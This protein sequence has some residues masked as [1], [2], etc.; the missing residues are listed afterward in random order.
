MT[1]RIVITFVPNNASRRMGRD[2][3]IFAERGVYI[4]EN[5]AIAAKIAKNAPMTRLAVS[6]VPK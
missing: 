6:A 4:Y 5:S 2:A 3:I 1:N